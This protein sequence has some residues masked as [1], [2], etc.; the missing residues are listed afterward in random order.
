MLLAASIILA[1]TSCSHKSSNAAEPPPAAQP[2][3]AP[4]AP[5]A[6]AAASAGAGGQAAERKALALTGGVEKV[7]VSSGMLSIKNDDVP[8]WGMPPM[9]M[10]YHVSNPQVLG[11]IKPGDRI[12]ATVYA[13]DFAKLYDVAVAAKP[14]A[15]EETAS[16]SALPPLSYVCPTTGEENE[17]EDKPGTCAKSPAKLVPIRLVIAYECLK[18]PAYIQANP[19]TCRYDKSEL[20][21]I[22]AS[23]F[24]ACG[25]NP[26][27]PRYL[28]PGKCTDGSARR[29]RFEKRPHGDH[30]P[31]HGGPYVAM[32]E[33]LLHHSEGTFIAPD[34]FRAYFYDEYTRPMRVAGYSARLVPTDS[35]AKEIGQPM[36]MKAA[37]KLGPNVMEARVPGAALPTSAAPLHFKLHVSVTPSAK[38]WTS[39]WDFTHYST[40]P[41]VPRPGGPATAPGAA[42]PTVTTTSTTPSPAAPGS[43]TTSASAGS[44]TAP[45][46][47]TIGGGAELSG[48]GPVQ[49]DP[50]PPTAAGILSEL[51]THT[52]SVA[53]LL[54]EGELGGLWVDALR[55]KDLAIALEQQHAKELP[56]AKRPQLAGAVKEMT[57]S[58]WE[59]DAAG[60]LG[61]RDKIAELQQVFATASSNIQALYG[62]AQH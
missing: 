40:E 28:E 22:T 2:V 30:N 62:S 21:P 15:A 34:V 42:P 20:A 60:D 9:S 3:K 55:S 61:Q 53:Q 8:G 6:A 13:G 14:P 56:E 33:D 31:R 27:D 52:D 18:G 45:A 19:G 11:S 32:S 23:M 41:G 47:I 38:D 44:A 54:N 26:D 59:I 16:K 10:S 24:W 49:P 58:A 29:Q 51:K 5:Q 57:R 7:D 17:I 46:A 48:G 39:D 37:P 1:G 25:D 35:N 12:T 36:T 43:G 50:V 4:A